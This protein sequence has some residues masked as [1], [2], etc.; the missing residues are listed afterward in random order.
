MIT[1]RPRLRW[2][3]G[4]AAAALL[5]PSVAGAETCLSPYVRRLDRMEKYLYVFCV[6]A[7]AQDNDFVITI[8]VDRASPTFGTIIHT[9]DLGSKGNET[10]HW[11]FTDDRT[12]IWAGGLFSSRIWIIDVATDPAAPRI[13]KV[14][15]DVPEQ[16]GLSGPHTYYALPGRMLLTFLGDAD[17][18]LPAGL[19]EFTNDG[20]FIRRI[21]QPE[22]AP[23]GYDVAVK[24]ELNRMVSSSFTPLRNYGRPFAEMDLEDFGNELIVWDLKDRRPIQVMEAGLAPLEVRWSLIPGKNYGFT[25]CA[26]DNSLY[27]FQGRGDG[28]YEAKK[29]ADTAA[30]PADLRQS[31]DDRFLYVSCFGGDEI[32]QWDVSDPEKPVLTSTVVPCVQPNMM[33]VTF[34]GKR[35]YVT[36]SLLS[37]LDR[38][39]NFCVRLVHIGPDGMKVD[40][41]FDIDLTRFPTG[42]ARGHDMLVN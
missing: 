22:D 17:G 24:P 39:E 38:S 40:P 16:T 29:V 5:I 25:N 21:D 42:P 36:N 20:R 41:F 11:G 31:P 7:D 26:L 14:L 33:H 37:T 28:T 13:E 32:Q 19:A 23:Y 9:L 8:D 27:L 3:L 12:R 30:L 6:D 1:R 15:D 34:D 2:L 18:G 35:M 10:H 4:L